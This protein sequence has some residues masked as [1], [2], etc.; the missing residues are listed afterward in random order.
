VTDATPIELDA[1]CNCRARERDSKIADHELVRDVSLA[2]SL[3]ERKFKS[4]SAATAQ[5]IEKR[6]IRIRPEP[7][8]IRVM[9]ELLKPAV[10]TVSALV[11]EELQVLDGRNQS[12]V[13]RSTKQ[14][15]I[16]IL[17]RERR[18]MRSLG[19]SKTRQTTNE[20]RSLSESGGRSRRD[21]L[22]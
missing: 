5:R 1:V 15:A 16:T 6:R 22:P 20:G 18:A 7:I 12:E 9:E 8:E 14:F 3:A 17:K 19:T 10:D 4:V 21:A 13:V 2:G 11:G